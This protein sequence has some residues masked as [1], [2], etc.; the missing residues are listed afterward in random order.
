V[1]GRAAAGGFTMLGLPQPCR[2]M[3]RILVSAHRAPLFS[4]DASRA[5]EQQ[6]Q[7]GL[8]AHTLMRR[9][10]RAVA[11]L[12]LAA[13]PQALRIWIVAGPGN[14]GGDGLDA[15]I[16]LQAAGRHVE[17]TLL[18]DA[19]RLPDDA[20]DALQRAREAGV[21][22]HTHL[23]P[24]TPVVD[25][26]VDG[27]LGLG[28]TRSPAG[29]LARAVAFVNEVPAPRLAIDLP[30]GLH[31]DTGQPLGTACVRATHTLALLTLKPG[32]FTAV[33][34]ELAGEIWFDDLDVAPDA[35]LA[36]AAWL[37][38]ADEARASTVPRHHAQHKGSF[39]DVMVIGGAP[40][41]SGA[42][43]LAARAALAAG[44]GR[45]YLSALDSRSAPIDL[46]RPELMLREAMWESIEALSSST[47]VCGCG[48]G[49][50]V[51]D[52]LPVVLH[53]AARL[54]LD[55]DALNA[56]AADP[57]L[58]RA[59]QARGARLAPTVLTPHPLEAGRLLDRDA[60]LVQADRLG[61]ADELARLFS[62]VVVLKGSGTIIA[63]PTRVSWINP[64]GNASLAT[65]G[66]GDVLAGWIGG[67]WAAHAAATTAQPSSLGPLQRVAA[68]AV[69]R[70]GAA[71]DRAVAEGSSGPLLAADLIEA[72]RRAA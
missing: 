64:T 69:W 27:L 37:T 23:P 17:V 19:A 9:A 24:T 12:A 30:S 46:Q 20:R 48:G 32:L 68:S 22:I 26:A 15:A 71:A 55:A 28:A 42:A 3:Q 39:G 35:S 33:G 72:M 5:I 63:A 29:E 31:A 59:L 11:R 21:A 58:H 52:V 18:A 41:M 7:A 25:L 45:V 47:V 40:G 62:A 66:T 34:R 2:T 67:Q 60:R 36:P 38:G 14:N 50:A 65:A 54:V 10:G 57:A 8:P 51:A 44:A 13:M 61:A 49:S 56:I 53:R 16:H 4:S 6:G 1:S 43:S 70:H